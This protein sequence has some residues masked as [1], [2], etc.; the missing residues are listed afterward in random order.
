MSIASALFASAAPVSTGTSAAASGAGAA[1]VGLFSSKVAAAVAPAPNKESAAWGQPAITRLASAPMSSAND[2]AS[3][4]TPGKPDGFGVLTPSSAAPA[5]DRTEEAAPTEA[6]DKQV[7][8]S[9]ALA[10]TTPVIA[11]P[12]PV[13]PPP[14]AQPV[15]QGETASA[16]AT[17]EPSRPAS[18]GTAAERNVARARFN[19]A[20]QTTAPDATEIETQKRLVEDADAPRIDPQR[21]VATAA[22]EPMK[23]VS[24]TTATPATSPGQSAD[25]FQTS[26]TGQPSKNDDAI[27]TAIAKVMADAQAPT[28]QIQI[29]TAASAPKPAALTPDAAAAVTTAALV[30][31][32]EANAKP[33]DAKF[34]L[35]NAETP[36]PLRADRHDAGQRVEPIPGEASSTPAAPGVETRTVADAATV[37][38]KPPAATDAKAKPADAAP[39]DAASSQDADGA[40]QTVATGDATRAPSSAPADHGPPLSTLSHA[41]VETTAHLAAQIAR[42]LDGRSTRF[43][44]VL[45]PE[46]LGRVDVSLEIGKD[47][48]LSARLAFDNPAAAADLRGRADELRRQLEA[49]GFQMTEDALDFSQ[50]DPSAGGGGFERQQQRNALF[51]GGGRLAAQADTPVLPAPGAWTN[52]SLTPDRVDLKV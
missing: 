25:G 33:D 22:T 19:L 9:D 46:D 28:A 18:D 50:R 37:A 11:Q 8:D 2:A 6:A 12:T 49:A 27:K 40:M 16:A 4:R 7:A 48:Q 42:R 13:V 44:M 23:A 43:D 36:T 24:T 5:D 35:P 45:T 14:S 21:Q 15:V 38:P 39:T 17:E 30:G 20:S 10:S 3:I 1:D 29:T 51:A 34:A 41:T 32:A 31:D 47:G 52:H 26:A